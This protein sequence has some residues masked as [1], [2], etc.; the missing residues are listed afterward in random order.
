MHDLT[1]TQAS[2]RPSDK[3]LR[4]AVQQRIEAAL[5]RERA[6]IA[7][8]LHDELGSA[9]AAARLELAA[10]RRTIADADRDTVRRLAR[11]GEV[12][13]QCGQ[14]RRSLVQALLPAP[15]KGLSLAQTLE[16][17]CQELRDSQGLQIDLELR[18]PPAGVVVP[19]AQM[20]AAYRLVQEALTNVAQHAGSPHAWVTVEVDSC[21]LRVQVLDRGRGFQPA[22]LSGASRGLAGMQ[23]RVAEL[24]GRWDL[25]S[26]LGAG[27][28]VCVELPLP[29]PPVQAKA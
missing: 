16:R 3:R 20:H 17:L 22:A 6:R 26:A 21:R 27:T 28:R 23:E 18:G 10:I 5:M 8:E 2:S 13:D 25:N 12:L 19:L 7:R 4:G 11:L 1:E 24:Q 15:D 29:H 9:L 14:A